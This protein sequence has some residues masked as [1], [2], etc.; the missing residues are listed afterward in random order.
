[1]PDPSKEATQAQSRADVRHATIVRCDIVGSTH[2]KKAL[3]LDGQ[4][5]FKD[6]WERTVAEVTSRHAGH[7]ETF[8]G[9]GALLALGHPK[10]REDMAEV[11]VRLGLDLVDAVRRIRVGAVPPMEVRVG[12]ATGPVVTVSRPLRD[13]SE[14]IAGITID[15]AERLRAFAQPGQVV[16]A[17]A[18]RMLAGRFFDYVDLG[19]VPMK[20]FEEGMRAWR[21]SGPSTIASRYEAQRFDARQTALVGRDEPLAALRDAWTQARAG[22]GTAAVLVGDAGIGKSRLAREALAL[23]REAGA[24]ILEIDCTP[25]TRNTPLYPI[26]VLLRRLASIRSGIGKSEQRAAAEALLARVLPG[27]AAAAALPFVAPLFGIDDVALPAGTSPVEVRERSVG[28]IVDML[29]GQAA[30]G[31]VAMLCEDAHWVDDTTA[32]VLQKAAAAIGNLPALLLVTT[33]AASDAIPLELP[34]GRTVELVPLDEA[35]ATRLV[36]AV[37]D[38]SISSERVDAIV[39]RCEGNPLILEEVA[40]SRSDAAL[41]E[42]TPGTPYETSVPTTLELVVQSRLGRLDSLTSLAQTASVLGREFPVGLL[43]ELVPGTS[44]AAIVDGINALAREGLIERGITA[45][46]ERARFKHVMIREAVYNTLLGQDRQQLHSR[47]ADTLVARHLGTPD[48][49]PDVLADHLREAKRF[50]EAVRQ[51]LAASGATAARGAYVETEGHCKVALDIVGQVD[52]AAEARMLRFRLL[53]QLGVALAG[54][55][56]Y[57]SPLVEAVYRDARAACGDSTE[58]EMLYPIMRALAALNLVRGNL[59]AGHELS[60][61]ALAVA[62][63]SRRP[64][65]RIDAMSVHCYALLYHGRLDETRA[66]I[67]HCLNLYYKQR[68]H[69]FT[70]PVPNDAGTA[71]FALL[72]TVEWLLGDSDAAQAAIER[73]LAHVDAVDRDFDRAMIHAWIAGTRYTQ[74]RYG[75]VL[76]HAGKAIELAQRG[77]F[78]EWLGVGSLL[79]L[80]AQAA[81]APNAEVLQQ[82]AGICTAFAQEGVGLNASYYLWG[83][84]RGHQKLGDAATARYLVA[85]AFKRAQASDETRMDAELLILQASLED[86]PASA[87]ELRVRALRVAVAQGN[88]ANALRAVATLAT[89]RT[90]DADAAALAQDT[91][92]ILEGAADYPSTARWMPTRLERLSAACGLGSADPGAAAAAP[93]AR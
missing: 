9:D 82:A 50:V 77:G 72:P 78:K 2:I 60:L 73:A 3:D 15:V 87:E 68:G 38:A 7:V 59:P 70:Y 44:P 10:P 43:C 58:A 46:D 42:E 36:R 16:I 91:L 53:V 40:R 21:V 55:H 80:L 29:A 49:A 69:R 76:Q 39:R 34:G 6:A 64:E 84:A 67:E 93:T 56:G 35:S 19:V 20:G 25:G 31:P 71:A 41:V 12:I 24:A 30:A 85:E 62:Q 90:L 8:E 5:A 86:D 26:G 23:A 75:D 4:F 27:A 1:M 51:R 65:F 11:A 57:S 66:W 13:K 88:V 28:A 92:A 54:R 61:E 83:L 47:A 22:H 32:T 18:T 52:D 89:V 45:H 81:V 48:A 79:A 37:A 74:R 17:D 63:R 33:R 14:T